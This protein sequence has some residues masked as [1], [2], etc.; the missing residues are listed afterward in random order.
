MMLN[1]N[2]SETQL[3]GETPQCTIEDCGL[4]DNYGSTPSSVCATIPM[5]SRELTT[6]YESSPT[7]TDTITHQNLNYVQWCDSQSSFNFSV[8]PFD[9]LTMSSCMVQPAVQ[10]LQL[11]TPTVICLKKK[12]SLTE[13][14]VGA[15]CRKPQI[16]D[17]SNESS[18]NRNLD[19][20]PNIV[21]FP[22]SISS[23]SVNNDVGYNNTPVSSTSCTSVPHQSTCREVPPVLHLIK[24]PSELPIPDRLSCVMSKRLDQ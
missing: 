9:S 11:Q 10:H 19:I 15:Q 18:D 1:L 20:S 2:N 12:Q 17:K 3:F 8:A 16:F 7:G 22:T 24:Y 13:L 23:S 4:N 14:Q 6:K 21:S 5:V